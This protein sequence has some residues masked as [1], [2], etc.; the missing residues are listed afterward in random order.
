MEFVKYKI[1]DKVGY[2][3]INRPEMRNALNFRI[4][5]ELEKV[6][7][8]IGDV[9][10]VVLSGTEDYFSSGI[11]LIELSGISAENI[12]N[13]LTELQR[14]ITSIERC[15]VPVIARVNGY[16]FGSAL[17]IALAADFIVSDSNCKFGMFETKF[18]IIPDL[19]G[20]TRL[21]KRVGA[22][23]AKK[24]IYLADTFD[25]AFAYNLG[26]VDW[27]FDDIDKGISELID[28]LRLNSPAA[29]SASKK[30][31]NQIYNADLEDNL[32]LEK[33]TQM[34]LITGKEVKL[35]I[36]NYLNSLKI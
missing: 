11:D 8:N 1:I 6:F 32:F 16:C 14:S 15:E 24:I 27:I 21:I 20:T 7:D 36:Q 13:K 5:E 31:I 17:E 9:F 30:L 34:T 10:C 4:F 23:I 22:S 35:R 2:V 19:G 12:E 29:I 18:G 25:T 28:K 26:L 33:Q 3:S